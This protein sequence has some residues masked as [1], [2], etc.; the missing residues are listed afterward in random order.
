MFQADQEADTHVRFDHVFIGQVG[1]DA[2]PRALG[3]SH[4]RRHAL[5]D[6]GRIR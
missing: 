4:I 6:A 5:N 1:D 3:L 2:R